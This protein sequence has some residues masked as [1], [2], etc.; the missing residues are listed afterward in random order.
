MVRDQIPD[1][2]EAKGQRPVVRFRKSSL[3]KIHRK[4]SESS[5]LLFNITK[6]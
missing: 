6:L 3:S 2:I 1:L 5:M 4:M